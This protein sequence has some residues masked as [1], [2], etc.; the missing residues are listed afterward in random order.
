MRFHT[1]IRAYPALV[2]AAAALG[3]C[4]LLFVLGLGPARAEAALVSSAH[5]QVP[6][7]RGASAHKRHHKRHQHRSKPKKR[8][9]RSQ[10]RVSRLPVPAP[11]GQLPV[12]VTDDQGFT[13][14]ASANQDMTAYDGQRGGGSYDNAAIAD[15]ALSHLGQNLFTPGPLD[16]GQCKQAVND[17]VAAASHNTQ[18]LGIDYNTNYARQGGQPVGRDDVAKGDIIQTFNPGNESAYVPGM[19]TA[20][21]LSHVPGSNMFEV[22]DSN[23]VARDVV[24]R[25]NWDPFS[26]AS[27]YGLRVAIWRMGSVERPPTL[28]P[29][30]PTPQPQPS[31]APPVFAETAGGVAHTWTNYTNAGGAA[32]PLIGPS[33]TVQIACKLTGFRVADGNTWWYRIASSPWNSAYYVSADAFYNNGATS[34]SL[35]GTPFVD[36]AVPDC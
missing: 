22:V 13:P 9:H 21:V 4:L 30:P 16:H 3:C 1:T 8:H 14:P 31:Q 19:H 27:R 7:A 5:G 33:Q 32:G 24:G 35:H 29:Q 2:A 6:A 15:I 34:G 11:V 28:Q 20:V 23:Y 25:H 26:A 36:P 17:W 12:L 18:R 10:R